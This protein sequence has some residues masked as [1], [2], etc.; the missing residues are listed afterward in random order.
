MNI[1]SLW[2]KKNGMKAILGTLILLV[3]QHEQTW[4][5]VAEELETITW[6][7]ISLKKS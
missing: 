1:S 2:K 3:E 7:T 6:V 5:L 4:K